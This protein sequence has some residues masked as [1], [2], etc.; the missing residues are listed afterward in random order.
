MKKAVLAALISALL[1][2]LLVIP[3]AAAEEAADPMENFENFKTQKGSDYVPGSFTDVSEDAWFGCEK[4]GVIA[5]AWEYGLVSGRGDGV[6]DPNGALTLAEA[7]KLSAVI[8]SIFS[9]GT[10][11]FEQGSPWYKVYVDYAVEKGIIK[12]TD[13]GGYYERRATREEAAYIFYGSVPRGAL[14]QINAVSGPSDTSNSKY[15]DNI[16]ILYDAG[17][18]QGRADGGFAPSDKLTR[19]EA[20]ALAVRIILPEKRVHMEPEYNFTTNDH[21]ELITGPV[22]DIS[23]DYDCGHRILRTEDGGLYRWGGFDYPCYDIW[24]A[25]DYPSYEELP[26]VQKYIGGKE[27]SSFCISRFRFA[28]VDPQGVLWEYEYG[29]DKK[30]LEGVETGLTDINGGMALKTDGTVWCW[31][32]NMD[33]AP[34]K[35]IDGAVSIGRYDAIYAIKDDGTLWRWSYN[36]ENADPVL[37]LEDVEQ[38]RGRLALK[39]DGSVWGWNIPDYSGGD[40][41]TYPDGGVPHKLMDNAVMIE[42]GFGAYAAITED[43]KL[44]LWGVMDIFDWTV[45]HRF[46]KEP[47]L[48]MEDVKDVA[49]GYEGILILKTNGELWEYLKKTGEMIQIPVK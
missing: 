28:Y 46:V 38:V 49:C 16:R 18:L 10:G 35:V 29:G 27:F 15:S 23:S 20:C 25:F 45:E 1:L 34:F 21:S 22:T 5:R 9:G 31:G 36:H 47:T 32:W 42:S 26:M 40:S 2:S 17:I 8:H 30:L 19:A 13:F 11:K 6:F 7:I 41:P 37:V 43:G 39:T 12:S 3:G 44:Y 48:F 33:P 24:D 14:P 4:E